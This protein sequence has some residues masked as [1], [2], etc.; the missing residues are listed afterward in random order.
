MWS[1]I[2]IKNRLA[3]YLG[4]FTAI[5]LSSFFWGWPGQEIH[6][7]RAR[8]ELDVVKKEL[9]GDSR[10][11]ELKMGVGTMDLGRRILVRGT[12]PDY[13]SL[14]YLKSVMGRNVSPKFNV[15]YFVQV[16]EENVAPAPRKGD[17]T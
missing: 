16:R 7:R 6:M 10:F 1:N 2:K 14:Q 12:V 13:E 11:S 5:I 15:S 4:I 8:K 3:L 9:E 17:G